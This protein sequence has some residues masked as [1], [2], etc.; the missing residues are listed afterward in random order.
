MSECRS[1]A[2]TSVIEALP[3]APVGLLRLAGDARIVAANAVARDL[4]GLGARPDGGWPAPW[5]VTREALRGPDGVWVAAGDDP[6]RRLRYRRDGE[7]WQVSLPH[8]ETAALLRDQASPTAGAAMLTRMAAATPPADDA[9]GARRLLA[10]VGAGLA[11]CDLDLDLADEAA[12]AADC[13]LSAGFGNLTEAIRQAVSLSVEIAGAVPQVV[14]DNDR[15]V[16]QSQAQVDAL[17]EV[18]AASRRLAEGVQAA[19]AELSAVR[20]EAARAD[21]S[22]R[23]GHQAAADLGEAIR[24]VERRVARATEVIE[25]IDAVSMQT[26][27]LSVNAGI[28]AAHAGPA[29]RGFAVVATEIRLLAERAAKASREVR[30]IVESTVAALGDGTASAQQTGLVL[31]DVGELLARAGGAMASVATRI[32]AQDAEIAAIDGAVEHATGLGRSNLERAACVAERSEALGRSVAELQDCVGLFQLPPDPMCVARHAQVRDLAC[33]TAADI[34]RALDAAVAR[35]DIAHDALFDRS[36]TPIPGIEPPRFRTAFDA[37]CDQLLPPLQEPVLD[38]HPWI[39]FAICA[40]PDGY[41]PTH[42]QRFSK[43]L[44]GHRDIDLVGNRTKRIFGDRVGRSVGAHTDPF[45]LQ[46]YRRD[47]GEIMFDLSVPIF[48]NGRHWGGFRLGYALD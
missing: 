44:T 22:V 3:D 14:E 7:G 25:V 4:L 10:R 26:N 6:A 48:V 5:G 47:T 40:N 41:V 33:T 12:L 1:V 11:A 28:Q 23:A 20:A 31:A 42:N 37:A 13:H 21:A 45:R 27:L 17:G 39:A 32:G 19:A 15:L 9:S 30:D 8:A 16:Q 29:G 35:G 38:A 43:P 18:L 46:V 24:E 2:G 36:Y 34:G